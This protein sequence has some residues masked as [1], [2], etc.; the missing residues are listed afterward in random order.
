VDG[1][2]RRS[3]R[4]FNQDLM[5]SWVELVLVVE[6]LVLTDESDSLVWCYHKS[7]VYSAQSLYAII[8]YRGVRP[9]YVPAIWKLDAPPKIQL[10][11][12]LLSHNK[13]ATIDNLNKKCMNKPPC[14]RC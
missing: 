11:L 3:F 12:W 1:K 7:G 6:N 13:L 5:Q 8:N 10:F 2:I 4:T 14:C 9:V